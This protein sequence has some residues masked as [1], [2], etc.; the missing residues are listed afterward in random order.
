M[1]EKTE[2]ETVA[3][4]AQQ[5]HEARKLEPGTVYLAAEIG[6]GTKQ[7][8][9]DAYSDSP[10]RATATRKVTTAESFISYL[11][12]HGR[13]E[14]EVYADVKNSKVVGII[15]SHGGN[16]TGDPGWQG[17]RV[18]LLLEHTKSWLA[19]MENDGKWLTQVQ[20]AEFIE[21]FS[22]DVKS[23]AA[24]DLMILAQNFYMTKDLEYQSSERLDNG[25]TNLVYKEKIAA[26]G[27]G[28]IEVPSQLE[29]I[30]QPYVESPRQY[31]FANFRTR[32]NGAQLLVGYV[33]IRPDDI[34]EGIFA[35]I[36]SEIRDGRKEDAGR[37]VTG[38][39]GITQP[40]YFG[41]PQ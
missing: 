28:N 7:F 40:I 39:D 36:V 32:L 16:I 22:P 2:A 3:F 27:T 41:R 38:F 30:L 34:L 12:K 23:P 35:D 20:F 19:W 33:L 25:E 26:K 4:I 31:A 1:S 15:D 21:Q 8:D 29:L 10:R 11:A 5:A 24:G 17:H 9:T 6:G 37:G 13:A 14:S 18:E